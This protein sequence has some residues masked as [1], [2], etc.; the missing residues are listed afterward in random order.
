MT[1]QEF[2]KLSFEAKTTILKTEADLI[3]QYMDKGYLI[4]NYQLENF[5][6]EAAIDLETET[7]IEIM[8]F[9]RGF[10]LDKSYLTKQQGYYNLFSYVQVA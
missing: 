8:P 2:T 9:K 6:V 1:I 3:D 10:L 5:F 4:Y 7:M